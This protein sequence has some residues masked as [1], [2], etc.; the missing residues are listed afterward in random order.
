MDDTFITYVMFKPGGTNSNFVPL[1]SATWG[2]TMSAFRAG[3]GWVWLTGPVLKPTGA[4]PN[5]AAP[6]A[7]ASASTEPTWTGINSAL[8]YVAAP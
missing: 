6:N 7:F 1:E 2:Y 8:S 5:A 3:G 4:T